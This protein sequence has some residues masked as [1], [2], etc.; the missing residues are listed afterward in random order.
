MSPNLTRNIA[1]G[2]KRW[3]DY[4]AIRFSSLSNRRRC[5]SSSFIP[6]TQSSKTVMQRCLPLSLTQYISQIDIALTLDAPQHRHVGQNPTVSITI[7]FRLFKTAKTALSHSYRQ[8]FLFI[9][10]TI[11]R[12]SIANEKSISHY[13]YTRS[14][15]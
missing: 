2:L 6:K 15:C 11:E 13:C 3:V 1:D 8:F 5:F 10:T 12:S 4:W 14:R 7:Y 9:F